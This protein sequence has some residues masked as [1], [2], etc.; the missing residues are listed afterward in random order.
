VPEVGS[1]RN[2]KSL[3]NPNEFG[4]TSSALG[5][6]R[7]RSRKAEPVSVLA[8]RWL[9][10]DVMRSTGGLTAWAAVA[11]VDPDHEEQSPP[12]SAQQ[13]N[14]WRPVQARRR[15]R[16]AVL[17]QVSHEMTDPPVPRRPN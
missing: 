12:S 5:P 13:R 2:Q 3:T 8:V 15:S 11:V 17:H 14:L 6:K 4:G 7:L 16:A 10:A 1:H 9:D